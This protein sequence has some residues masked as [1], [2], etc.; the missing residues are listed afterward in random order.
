[1]IP[2][3]PAGKLFD[4]WLTAFNTGEPATILAFDA[5][6]RLQPRSIGQTMFLRATTGGFTPIRVERNE[7]HSISMLVQDNFSEQLERV[8]IVL[9]PATS[10][11]VKQDVR[12]VSRPA[13]L[14]IPRLTESGAVAAL[15]ERAGTAATADQFSGVLLVARGDRVLLERAWGHANREAHTP[16]TLDTRF[17]VASTAK[18]C[19]AVATLQLVETGRLRLDDVVGKHIPE[20]ENKEI[21]SKVTIRH[22]LMHTGG[23]GGLPAPEV[24]KTL[25]T[26]Q[27][28]IRVL[29][30]RAPAYEPGTE[31]QYSNYGYIL[32][33]ELVE[34]VSGMPF[35]E[36]LKRR[37]FEPA[38]MRFSSIG[39]PTQPET[40]FALGYSRQKGQLMRAPMTDEPFPVFSTARDLLLFARSLDSGRLISK[41]MLT[42]AM[43]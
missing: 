18:M 5:A 2:A 21:A 43:S 25:R 9:D 42:E 32:L 14:A 19:E 12:P 39:V 17:A 27:D 24:R 28:Y 7:S 20:Y 11:I 3:T 38:G 41:A 29:G 6:N 31:Y 23:T 33:A 22:L 34:R 26:P 10:K 37:I 35:G 1:V 16:V 30:A 4:A 15:V 36:Y 40:G 13:D 8:D